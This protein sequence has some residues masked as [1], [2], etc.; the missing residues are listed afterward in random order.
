MKHQLGLGQRLIANT[1]V[2]LVGQAVLLA[3]TFF[4]MPYITNHFGASLFGVYI[5]LITYIEI[6]SLINATVN[7]SLVKEV[8]E[9]LPQGRTQDIQQHF[10]ITLGIFLGAGILIPLIVSAATPWMV[11]HALTISPDMRSQAIIGFWLAGG[12]FFV[13]L[14]SQAF[15]SISIAMQRFDISNYINVGSEML[16]IGATVTVIFAGYRLLAVMLVTLAT[17]ILALMANILTTKHLMPELRLRPSFSHSHFKEIFH[18]SKHVLIAKISGRI[19]SWADVGIIGYLRP[20]ADVAFYGVPYSIHARLWALI[21]NAAVAVFPAASSLSGSNEREQL[22]ELYLRATKILVLLSLFPSLALCIYSRNFL[23][24][25]MG[26]VFAEH[27]ALAMQV[28]MLA[29]FV[30]SLS[31]I[32]Y[33]VLQ[34]AGHVHTTAQFA[35]GNS[36]CNVVLF[37]FLIPRF[38]INGAAAGFLL[39]QLVTAP[40]LIQFSNRVLDLDWKTVLTKA[41]LPVFG[42]IVLPSLV[43]LALRPWVSSFESLTVVVGASGIIFVFMAVVMILDT[44]ERMSCWTFLDALRLSVFSRKQANNA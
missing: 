26:P 17:S 22:R 39:S 33:T 24:Y 42:G 11:D 28:L 31:F 14:V 4:S 16:R 34:C 6:F 43:M 12:A 27:G 10:G 2:N 20:V 37:L 19:V 41:F 30:S 18:F 40:P 1:A 44:K 3:I 7:T 15:G 13:R 21:A 29:C 25:W 32:P 9:L 23:T 8:A 38:G 36:V 5:L 35:L